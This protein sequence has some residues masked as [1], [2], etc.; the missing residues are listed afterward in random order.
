[1]ANS[2]PRRSA[3]SLTVGTE[4]DDGFRFYTYKSDGRELW[5]SPE[6]FHRQRV[7]GALRAAKHRAKASSLPF[8]IDTDYL[9]SV[10]PQDA[11][12]PVLG[13]DL[14]WGLADGRTN[15]P[16]LDRV[17]PELGYVRGN[18]QWISDRANIIKSNA[19]SDELYAVANYVRH[20]ELR[21]IT[22]AV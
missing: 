2:S 7:G 5:L 8:D 21:A 13:I 20:H 4:R 6:A 10:F 11:K 9:L 15:S 19:T 22:R 3:S 18:V 17:F 14:V 12:C 16:S 1:M